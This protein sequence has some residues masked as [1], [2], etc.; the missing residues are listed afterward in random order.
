MIIHVK[1]MSERCQTVTEVVYHTIYSVN[2]K[3]A[4]KQLS[5]NVRKV[6]NSYRI[7]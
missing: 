5:D 1:T 6:S 4:V 3:Q 7:V 2:V